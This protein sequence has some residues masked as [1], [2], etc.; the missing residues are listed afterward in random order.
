MV[1]DNPRHPAPDRLPGEVKA[2]KGL[3]EKITIVQTCMLV[4]EDD[5]AMEKLEKIENSLFDRLPQP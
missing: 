4:C 3:L 2:E 5:E 1:A